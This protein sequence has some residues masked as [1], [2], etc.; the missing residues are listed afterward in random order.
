[1]TGFSFLP[2]S[3]E[4]HRGLPQ[5]GTWV[6]QDGAPADPLQPGDYPVTATCKKCG[7][8]IRLGRLLQLE[9]RH[10]PDGAP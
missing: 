8:R 7:A 10:V 5:P 4:P 9:W 1:V 2:D 3:P 6:R